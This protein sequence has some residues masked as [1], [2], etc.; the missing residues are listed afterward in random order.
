MLIVLASLAMFALLGD[1]R[2]WYIGNFDWPGITGYVCNIGLSWAG[3][4]GNVDSVWINGNM[5]VFIVG[6]VDMV[7]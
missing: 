6:Y 3:Y 1:F 5:Y 7:F 4:I 2:W